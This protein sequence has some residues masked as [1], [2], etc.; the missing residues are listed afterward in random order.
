M[1]G[2]R[3]LVTGGSGF[4][5]SHL[6]ERLVK[7]GADVT[8]TT[9]YKNSMEN[10][11]VRKIWDKINLIEL[12]IRDLDSLKKIRDIEPEIIFHLAAYI[13]VGD[14]FVHVNEALDTN[15]KGTAN[16]IESYGDYERF[17]YV[18][19]SEVYGLQ[20]TVPFKETA[21][22]RPLSPYAI[23]KY[24]GELYC[25]MKYQIT[26]QP[27]VILRPFNAFGPKQSTKAIIPEL[28]LNCLKNKEI[29]TTKGKQTREFN[30][31]ENIIDGFILAAQKKKAVGQVINIGSGNEIAIKDL[32]L[33]IAELTHTK[34]ELKIGALPYRPTEIWRMCADNSRAKKILGWKP[35]ISFEDGL[36]KTIEWY[37]KYINFKFID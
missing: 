13:H 17:I 6:T 14:S 24:T 20:E 32:V 34:S 25:K 3:V 27:I 9:R 22:P 12:D 15:G 29:K 28:I 16:L 4:I 10:I 1:K 23:G 5:G 2:K 11:R 31:V 7:L 36:K 30:F 37:K 35:K 33:K 19:S 8:I 18:S 26:K 21:Q